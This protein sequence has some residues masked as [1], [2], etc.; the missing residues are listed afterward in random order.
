M[1]RKQD[2]GKATVWM[3]S[4]LA[5]LAAGTFSP[6]CAGDLNRDAI[7]VIIGNQEY[8][9]TA[10]NVPFARKDAEAVRDFAEDRLGFRR[11]RIFVLEN[12]TGTEL[13]TWFG[14]SQHPQGRLHDKVRPDRSD[15]LVFYSGHGV[16]DIDSEEGYLLPVD[17]DP[18]YVAT[19]GY[20][21]ELLYE[22]LAA[23]QARSVLVALDACFS[24]LMENGSLPGI[25]GG[26]KF[27]PRRPPARISILTAGTGYQVAYTDD[28]AKHGLFTAQLLNGLGGA[29][30]G[31]HWGDGNGQVTFGELEAYLSERVNRRAL[32]LKG[33]EQTP[34]A[35]GNSDQVLA[36][37]PAF[38]TLSVR[39]VPPGAQ[40]RIVTNDGATSYREGMRVEPGRYRIEVEARDHEPFQ[41]LLDVTGNTEYEI[42]LCRL[43][44]VT[45][46]ECRDVEVTIPQEEIQRSVRPMQDDV[47][48][49]PMD[50]D[51]E[52]GGGRLE[53]IYE[54]FNGRPPRRARRDIRQTLCTLAYNDLAHDIEP[55]CS[56]IDGS[57]VPGSLSEDTMD[58]ECEI[59]GDYYSDYCELTASWRCSVTE[60]V[61][62]PR[63]TTEKKC[64]ERTRAEPRCPEKQVTLRSR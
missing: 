51:L 7:A 10:W 9:N 13:K 49:D 15:V 34:W 61:R 32:E 19:G 31:R 4:L 62:V 30:D 16:P 2:F 46:Q 23:L 42:S 63:V 47:T 43:E 54:S 52:V 64:E 40:I 5:G 59:D 33:R 58:C 55:G 36:T 35:S 28:D 3:V 37:L 56:D 12:A 24:G 48:K 1:V 8:K 11:D 14:S 27:S 45:K 17:A 6:V 20:P 41:Q 18:N 53:S 39:T 60:V 44:Q 57:F 22:Q 25:K 29:A 50:A 21:I 26:I 38:A